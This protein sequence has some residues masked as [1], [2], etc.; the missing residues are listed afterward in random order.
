[1]QTLYLGPDELLV[2][3]KVAVHPTDDAAAVARA[4]DEVESRV[5]AAVPIVTAM[6]VEPDILRTAMTDGTVH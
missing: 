1:M 6:Y 4:I 3:M 5:R 2:A